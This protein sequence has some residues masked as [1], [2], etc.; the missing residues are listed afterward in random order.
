MKRKPYPSDITDAQWAILE[1]LLPPALPGGRPREVNLR[2]V[3]HA[4]CYRNREGCSWRALPHDFPPWKTVYNYGHRWQGD[5]IWDRLVT[6]LREQVRVRAGREPTPGIA[7][8]DSQS[9]KT[10]EAGGTRGYDGGKKIQGRKRHIAGDTMGLLLA[11]VVT[12][13]SVAD[14]VGAKAV[15]KYLTPKAFPRLEVVRAD[16]AYAKYGLP[17]WV[18]RFKRFV[19]ELVRRPAKA[20]GWLLLPKRWVVER[21]FAWLGRYRIHSKDYERLTE[22]SETQVKISTVHLLLR[23]LRPTRRKHRFR[24]PKKR[25]RRV[26]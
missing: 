9:V 3:V 8:I 15:L 20:V 12:A 21:T 2:E 13:A 22:S 26:A 5:G 7:V 4:L 24:Y 25:R 1:P 19:L 18:Q 14:G 11:G 10:T 23:R 17:A 6:I 16:S